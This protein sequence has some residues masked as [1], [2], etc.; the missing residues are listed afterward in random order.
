M[1]LAFSALDSYNEA[2]QANQFLNDI[3]I[4]AYGK[5]KIGKIIYKILKDN[6]K[7]RK[8]FYE[9]V[10]VVMKEENESIR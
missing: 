5:A 9:A 2:L 10:K 1:N 8:Y 7:A 3:Q 4:Y 6:T